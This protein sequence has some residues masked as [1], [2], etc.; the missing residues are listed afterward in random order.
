MDNN[1][2][3]TVS[4][5]GL[6][7]EIDVF[8]NYI[9]LPEEVIDLFPEDERHIEIQPTS[10]FF[11]RLVRNWDMKVEYNKQLNINNE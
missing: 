3:V 4:Y 8:G 1:K 6:T 5:N 2:I 9:F 11:T 10:L 7:F